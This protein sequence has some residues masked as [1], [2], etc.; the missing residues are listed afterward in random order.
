LLPLLIAPGIIALSGGVSGL[1]CVVYCHI[2]MRA[3]AITHACELV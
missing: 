3:V 1:S 2:I